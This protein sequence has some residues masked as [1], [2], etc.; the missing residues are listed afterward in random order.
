MLTYQQIK[1][2]QPEDKMYAVT[3]YT[4]LQI[5]VFPSGTKTWHVNKSLHGKRIV[6]DLGAFPDVSLADAIKYMDSLSQKDRNKDNFLDLY[7]DWLELKKKSIKNWRDIDLRFQKYILPK[8]SKRTFKSITPPELITLLKET[9]ENQNKL[10]TI[11]R[12][13]I[14]FKQLEVFG[15]NS[16]RID[17]LRFQGI[18]QVF[19]NPTVT[20]RKAIHPDNLVEIFSHILLGSIKAHNTWCAI[21]I[22]FYTLLRP[23]EYCNLQWDWVDFGN[24]VITVPAEYMK[25]KE[26]HTV[27]ICSNL[28]KLLRSMQIVSK[29]ILPSPD[30]PNS[31]IS[32]AAIPAFFKRHG[33]RNL[34]PHGIRSIGRT[35]FAENRIDD[36]IGELCLAHKIGSRVTRAYKRTTLLKERAEAMQLWGDYVFSCIEQAKN[37]IQ[38][39]VH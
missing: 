10:E 4:G 33:I 8:F 21:Q 29:Y 34:Q 9:L 18:Q 13:C 7:K 2:L 27:P 5:R 11:K 16:G 6:K 1:A 26:E 24:K 23:G 15:V 32:I 12:I 19:P 3:V 39:D 20:H 30:K 35:W 31:A 37:I 22:A 36:D 25:M 28:L 14:W 17:S 38:K